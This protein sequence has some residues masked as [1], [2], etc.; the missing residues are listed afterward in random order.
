M[1][2]VFLHA[3]KEGPA[4]RSFGLQVAQLAGVPRAV[5][6]RAREYMRQLEAQG[7]LRLT[8]ASAQAELP[9]TS[10]PRA[11]LE[12]SSRDEPI[13]S[14]GGAA[15]R[16]LLD[17]LRALDPDALTPRSALELAYELKRRAQALDTPKGT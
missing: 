9:L 16:E 5:I 4:N 12:A 2:L 15:T 17:A 6:G 13:P 8:D 1:Q 7:T 11:A 14:A 3:V 10:A